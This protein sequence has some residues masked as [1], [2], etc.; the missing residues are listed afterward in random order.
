MDPGGGGLNPKSPSSGLIPPG[1]TGW[2]T[3]ATPFG[4]VLLTLREGRVIGL[5]FLDGR[6]PDRLPPDPGPA[7]GPAAGALLEPFRRALVAAMGG[8]IPCYHPSPWRE[9]WPPA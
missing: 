2:A 8:E 1:I 9:L 7:L 5:C 4:R 3:L 6:N